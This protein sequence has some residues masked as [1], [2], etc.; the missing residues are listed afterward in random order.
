MEGTTFATSRLSLAQNSTTG[1]AG[2]TLKLIKSRGTSN[3][4]FTSVIDDDRIGKGSISGA[5][6]TGEITAA[7]I[8]A[9]V[10]EHLA[11]MTCQVVL[12]SRPQRTVQAFNGAPSHRQLWAVVGGDDFEYCVAGAETAL[13]VE[14]T[15]C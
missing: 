5:D 6:G 12:C 1:N 10:T 14:G 4:S 8:E 9:F 3:G 11:Q 2:A 13:Q 7:T 15:H